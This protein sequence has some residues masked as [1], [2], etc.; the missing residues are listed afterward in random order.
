MLRYQT[1]QQPSLLHRWAAHVDGWLDLADGHER[2]VVVRYDGLAE[3]YEA[4]LKS[5]AAPLGRAP[6]DLTPPPRDHNV[7]RVSNA[8]QAVDPALL[9]RLHAA[10]R[11]LAGPTMRRAG[12][13]DATPAAPIP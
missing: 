1:R 6:A 2:V 10:C 4:T 12:Y 7:V 3:Y 8:G 11:D 13:G 5:L 9:D